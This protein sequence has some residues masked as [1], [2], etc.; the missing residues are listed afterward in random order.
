M[1]RRRRFRYLHFSIRSKIMFSVVAAFFMQG[2]F[3]IIMIS[4]NQRSLER[5]GGSYETNAELNLIST[6]LAD[7]EKAL[8][9]YMRYRR[10]EGIDSYYHYQLLSDMAISTL[11]QVPSA[12]IVQQKEYLVFQMSASF[13]VYSKAAVSAQRA[14]KTDEATANYKRSL[15]CYA[16]L[17]KQIE[18]LN[19]LLLKRNAEI[20]RTGKDNYRI[21]LRM[22]IIALIIFF[23]LMFSLVSLLLGALTKPLSDI[24]RVAMRVAGMDFDVPLFN[25]SDDGEIGNIC[26]AFDRMIVSI[27]EYIDKIWEKAAQ[28]NELKEKELE[29]RE[30]YA[31]AQLRAL[32]NQINPHFLFNTLNTGAQLA[33]MEGAD[34]TCYFMEQVADFFR[35]NIQQKGQ[36]ASI[37]E[38]LALV[39]NFV[40]IMKVRFGDRLEFVK[41][42][43]PEG[44]YPQ[45]LPRMTLQPLVENC[46]KYG[47]QEGKGRVV[48]SISADVYMT[49]IRVSDDGVGFPADL[50]EAL[51]AGEDAAALLAARNKDSGSKGGTGTGLSNVI[52]RLRLYFHRNDVFDILFNEEGGTTF[53]LRI[54]NV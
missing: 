18:E 45:L 22:S 36:A 24:S 2:I 44:H 43:P 7:C 50:R 14:N 35:Y 3:F 26:R 9:D 48:L 54:P 29:M 5:I 41:D 17:Q 1:R 40:Y 51:L 27:R 19:M 31:G 42:V 53:V 15:S 33:M 6:N 4:L 49:T 39:D 16:M 10:F 46:I 34:K 12:D 52:S 20:Y 11:Q 30:L 38:E 25:S 32:Q 47:L 8:E 13:F 37:E 21:F 28:E 23:T